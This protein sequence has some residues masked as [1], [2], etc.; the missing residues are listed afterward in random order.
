VWCDI[1]MFKIQEFYPEDKVEHFPKS[2]VPIY[3]IIWH[4]IPEDSNCHRI[5]LCCLNIMLRLLLGSLLPWFNWQFIPF[6]LSVCLNIRL[7]YQWLSCMFLCLHNAI[8]PVCFQKLT[9]VI[10]LYIENNVGLQAGHCSHP[11]QS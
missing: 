2:S 3:E 7:R 6:F 8:N 11:L 10:L 4:H 5:N 1:S 9:E